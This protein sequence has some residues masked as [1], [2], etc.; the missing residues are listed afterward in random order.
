M[1]P[2]S[3]NDIL[4]ALHDVPPQAWD[5]VLKFVTS[6]Q[7]AANEEGT[8]DRPIRTAADLASSDLVGLWADRT[9]IASTPAFADQLREGAQQR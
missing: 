3:E 8:P 9:E 2:V 4:H 5:S 7:S 6:L 1:T